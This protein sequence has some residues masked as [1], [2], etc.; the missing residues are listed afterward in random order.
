M[1][2]Q[3]KLRR[4]LLF[5]LIQE[6]DSPELPLMNTIIGPQSPKGKTQLYTCLK[7]VPFGKE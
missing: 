5:A 3:F 6:Q 7:Y 2:V 4:L 1:A